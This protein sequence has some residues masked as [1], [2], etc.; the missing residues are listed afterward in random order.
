M[1]GA[2][3][4][5][6][7]VVVP[8]YN[9]AGSLPVLY[10]RLKTAFERVLRSSYE[11]IFVDDGSDR[12]ETWPTLEAIRKGRKHVTIIRLSRNFGNQAATLCGIE[13]ARGRYIITMDDDLQHAPEDLP[14][15]AAQRAHDVVVARLKD[16]KHAPFK[17]LSSAFIGW[18]DYRLV[19]KPKT[20]RLST[21][22]LMQRRVAKGMLLIKTPYPY[23]PALMLQITRDIVNVEVAHRRRW[24]GRSTFTFKKMVRLA[25]NLLI[26]NSPFLLHLI[27]GIGIAVAALSLCA[28]VYLAA[29]KW[30]DKTAVQGWTSLIVSVL[31][32]G[33]VGLFSLSVIGEYLVR[34]IRATEQKPTVYIKRVK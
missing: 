27:G 23:L 29:R 4:V 16:K 7:S 30:L 21:F 15:L 34:I 19:G 31:F 24:E 20:I 14:I 8:V 33:G 26:N 9:S 25:S 2:T 3:G 10:E 13:R 28:G 5:V 11:I 22:R 12:A 17:R 32:F 6:Y 1:R 18:L